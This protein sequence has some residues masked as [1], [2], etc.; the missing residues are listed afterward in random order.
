MTRARSKRAGKTVQEETEEVAEG[1]QEQEATKER[2]SDDQERK[3]A[4]SEESKH[5][6]FKK[7]DEI[8]TETES[9]NANTQEEEK[10]ENCP[11]PNEAVAPENF[12]EGT[13]EATASEESQLAT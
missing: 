8:G 9:Q 12:E 10:V 13:E 11:E 2:N 3:D 7:A 5:G 4:E 6:D 1:D